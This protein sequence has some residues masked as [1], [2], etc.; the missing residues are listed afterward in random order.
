MPSS[1][2]GTY[3]GAP[4]EGPQLF[5]TSARICQVS[6]MGTG[7]SS[8]PLFNHTFTRVGPH[9]AVQ[10]CSSRAFTAAGEGVP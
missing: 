3:T 10:R 7:T 2:S 5:P 8:L 1:V 4:G 6:G 9:T